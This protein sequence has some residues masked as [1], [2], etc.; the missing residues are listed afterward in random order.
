MGN[1][2]WLLTFLF[3]T[4]LAVD[5]TACSSNP[6]GVVDISSVSVDPE[7]ISSG[8]DATFTL[9]GTSW[10]A[11]EGGTL[12][13]EPT[14]L[15]IDVGSSKLDI[16]SDLGIMCPIAV[17]DYDLTYPLAVPNVPIPLPIGG[18]PL[19]IKLTATDLDS[20]ELF[21]I[22]LIVK[23]TTDSPFSWFGGRRRTIRA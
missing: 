4:T 3:T 2:I 6:P 17:G 21:C 8:E 20:E 14:M 11:V 12:V 22:N 1:P 18:L 5:F 23:M 10:R 9:S 15:G 19:N 13:I 16:C 7:P